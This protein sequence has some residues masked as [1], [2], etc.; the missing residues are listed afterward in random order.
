MDLL[1]G[2]EQN[3]CLLIEL[4]NTFIFSESIYNQI[5][6]YARWISAY[7]ARLYEEIIPILVL[8][9]PRKV[10]PSKRGK[11]YKFLSKE[12]MEKT[13]YSEWYDTMIEQLKIG[14]ENLLKENIPSLQ[15]LE[16][17]LFETNEQQKLSSIYQVV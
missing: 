17:Y 12:D 14:R 4:K 2:T 7:K 6:E 13:I 11:K 9:A 8:K 3:R 1:F 15:K 5:K 16:V 10:A